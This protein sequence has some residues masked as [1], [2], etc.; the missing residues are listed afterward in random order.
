MIT[1]LILFREDLNEIDTS[2]GY[3]NRNNTK[4]KVMIPALYNI[5]KY[6]L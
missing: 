3:I 1:I 4:S 6:N 5:K 2:L